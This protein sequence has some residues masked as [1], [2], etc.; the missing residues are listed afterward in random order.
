MIKKNSGN[1]PS[2]GTTLYHEGTEKILRNDSECSFTLTDDEDR[3]NADYN[4]GKRGGNGTASRGHILHHKRQGSSKGRAITARDSRINQ[5]ILGVQKIND[6]PMN[7][8]E[9]LK[10][11]F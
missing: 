11:P 3:E 10:V 4:N 8:S 9:L 5:D 6:K 7:Q 1:N 2:S